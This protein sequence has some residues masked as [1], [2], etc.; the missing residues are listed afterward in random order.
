MA[1]NAVVGPVTQ[2]TAPSA[3]GQLSI[4]RFESPG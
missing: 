4:R 2:A 1:T 3:I